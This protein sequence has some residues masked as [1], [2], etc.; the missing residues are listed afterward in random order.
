MMQMRKKMSRM[1]AW[2]LAAILVYMAPAA[3]LDVSA[4]SAVLMDGDSGQVIWEKNSNEK[5]LIA[6]TTKIM[7]AL[8][9]LEQTEL[10]DI[11][12]VA[13]EAVGVEGSSMY[14]KAGEKLTVED[15]LYGLMLSSG[16]DAAVALAMYVAGSPEAFA[17]L[18]NEKAQALSL[19]NTHF[20][21][22][23][24]LDSEENYAT[25]RSLGILT[26]A[27]MENDDFRTIVSS[28]T[29]SCAGHSMTNHNKLLWQYDGAVGVKT[30]FTKHAGRIL[31]GCAEKNDRRL[32]SVTINAPSDWN[33]HKQMLDYGFSCYSE[34]TLVSAGDTVGNLPVISGVSEQVPLVAE[35]EIIWNMLSEELPELRLETEPFVYAP[36]SQGQ[37]LGTLKVYVGSRLVGE[38]PV[39]A[40]ES[41]EQL[42]EEPGFWDRLLERFS[43]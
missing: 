30:G 26:A 16:H 29:Y 32:I 15:L 25:A 1:A 5:S 18:M 40:G 37:E 33:D 27:A 28:K 6:S 7:T 43:A 35:R 13:A 11:V 17:E 4:H 9:V 21:N 10:S 23:N 19:Q 12:E 14:L 39:I 34:K 36:V 41:V 20:A 22:P 3:A 42:P 31:V 38:T 8:V 24:G 2:M